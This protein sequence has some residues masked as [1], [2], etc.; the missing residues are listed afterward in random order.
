[1]TVD[2]AA[3]RTEVGGGAEDMEALERT[4]A[5]TKTLLDRYIDDNLMDAADPVPTE[6]YDAAWLRMAIED[7][8]RQQAPNGYLMQQFDSG[9]GAPVP[10]RVSMDPY[11]SVRDLLVGWCL[12]VSIG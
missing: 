3:L 11:R 12:E 6:V 8:N 7:W 1:M 4:V 9:E 2:A 5:L 10:V